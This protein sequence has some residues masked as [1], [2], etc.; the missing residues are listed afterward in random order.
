MLLTLGD[1]ETAAADVLGA[2]D[3]AYVSGAAGEGR[4]RDANVAAFD[5]I[6]LLPKVLVDV[7]RRSTKTSVLGHE[8]DLPVILAPSA[9]HRI[10]HPD[11]ERATVRAAHAAGTIMVLSLGSSLPVEEVMAAASGPVWFQAYVGRDRGRTAEVLHRAQAAG[12]SGLV[13]TVDAPVVGGRISERRNG[14]EVRPEWFAAGHEPFY[15]LIPPAAAGAAA[16]ELWDPSLTWNDVGWLRGLTDL[17]LML[18]GILRAD[19]AAR[20]VAEGAE[21]VIVSNH[22]GRQLDSVIASMEALPEVSD[23]VG[24][25]ATVMV[26]GGIRRGGDVFKA[27]AQGAD[28]VLVGRPVMW[29]LAVGGAS[30]VEQVLRHLADELEL[31]MALC[32]ACTVEEITPDLI[33]RVET[34]V[35]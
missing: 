4:T 11:G 13:V 1:F 21:G 5:A 25:A 8:I 28:V 9:M 20:A 3:A 34:S 7:S 14:F 16:T 10:S 29:G 27:L 33:R 26:D 2:A 31:T 22:G 35:P 12:C 18:K 32:G 19:D 17:P 6:R 30:G 23:A 24:D 15:G